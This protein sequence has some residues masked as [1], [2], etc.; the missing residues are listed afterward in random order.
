MY[1]V[2]FVLDNP[3]LLYQVLDAWD[4]IGVSGVTIIESTGLNRLKLSRQ[5]GKAF[6]RGI[7]RLVYDPEEGHVTLLTI[8]QDEE[9]V[10]G[11]LRT[12]EGVVGNLDEPNNGIL[13]AW[14]MAFVKGVPANPSG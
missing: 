9:M 12:V 7:N 14:P 1:M 3:D 11:C 5:V 6:M 8:V 13:A 10:Q 2:M 4:S